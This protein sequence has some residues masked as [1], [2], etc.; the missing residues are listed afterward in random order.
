MNIPLYLPVG[1]MTHFWNK[2]Q[3][4]ADSEAWIIGLQVKPWDEVEMD[5]T[6]K[7][8]IWK[9]RDEGWEIGIEIRGKGKRN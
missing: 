5:N 4:C 2:K 7:Q 3:K 8:V 9:R 6:Q 1:D